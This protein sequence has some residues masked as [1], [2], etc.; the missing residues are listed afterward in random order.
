MISLKAYLLQLLDGF[1]ALNSKI[2]INAIV[3]YYFATFKI[4]SHKL[5]MVPEADAIVV[6]VIG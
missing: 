6:K 1:I 2:I 4:D 5:N 3:N